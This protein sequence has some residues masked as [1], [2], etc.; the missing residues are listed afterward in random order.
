MSTTAS[1][2]ARR[3]GSPTSDHVSSPGT[4]PRGPRLETGMP[5]V[6]SPDGLPASR[7]A[8]ASAKRAFDVALAASGLLVSAPLLATFALAISF[9]SEG[10]VLFHQLRVGLD[11]REFTMI[12][13]RTMDSHGRVTSVGRWL[14]PMGLDELPQLWNVL[15]G[16]MS[17]IGPRPEV[18]ARVERYRR[19]LPEYDVRH[20][21]RPGITGLAQVQGLRGD[22]TG[23][24][25]ERLRFDL[26]YVRDW[27]LALDARVLLRTLPR[28]LRDTLWAL[29]G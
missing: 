5:G 3:R 18:P 7:G 2:R 29:G 28:V 23:T 27:S 10:P 22:H 21:V 6:V 24:I 14:R 11:R 1:T 26:D 8:H 13:L 20:A 25:A 17:V 15:T 4:K 16:D 9:D 12:K 19:Q